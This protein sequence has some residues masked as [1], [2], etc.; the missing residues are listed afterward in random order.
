M[1]ALFAK[2]EREVA[3]LK[4]LTEDGLKI[5]FEDSW[6]QVRPSNTEPIV[7]VYTGATTE[8]AASALADEYVSLV[9]QQLA[10]K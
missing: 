6:V 10:R 1:T 8:E 5:D 2:L 4:P 7:R 9:E 3:S